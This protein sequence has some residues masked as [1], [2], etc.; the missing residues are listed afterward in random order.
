MKTMAASAWT[1]SRAFTTGGLL[2]PYGPHARPATGYDLSFPRRAQQR[3]RN[4]LLT[5]S[6]ERP[7]PDDKSFHMSPD[8]FR[9]HGH[10][11]IDWI[12]DYYKRIE[13]FPGLSQSKPGHLPSQLPSAAPE[14]SDTL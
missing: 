8:E 2:S 4:L 9:R 3:R 6:G 10:A 11:V 14:Q 7:V 13:S 1:T 12:A 5:T